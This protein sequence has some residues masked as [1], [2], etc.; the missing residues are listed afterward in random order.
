MN[1]SSISRG[2]IQ[3]DTGPAGRRASPA[4]SASGAATARHHP[5]R[6]LANSAAGS[7]PPRR[8]AADTS[9]RAL[10][11]RPHGWL[12]TAAT[13]ST[14][15]LLLTSTATAPVVTGEWCS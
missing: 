3:A 6:R 2:A 8:A 9:G 15:V 13:V 11:R 10:H 14:A 12:A 1:S 7:P 4:L 5:V